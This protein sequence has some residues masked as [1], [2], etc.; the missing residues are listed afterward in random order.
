MIPLTVLCFMDLCSCIRAPVKTCIILRTGPIWRMLVL[1]PHPGRVL[2][3]VPIL[4]KVY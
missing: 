3:E 2:A 4:L 1:A